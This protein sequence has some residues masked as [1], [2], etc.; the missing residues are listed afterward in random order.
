ME[1]RVKKVTGPDW[2]LRLLSGNI[3][4]VEREGQFSMKAE[5]LNAQNYSVWSNEMEIRLRGK[6]FGKWC[7]H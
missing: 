2:F 5:T 4:D 3:S 6:S 1:R 7:V